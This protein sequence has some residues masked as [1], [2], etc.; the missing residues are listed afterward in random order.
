MKMSAQFNLA[1]AQRLKSLTI[2]VNHAIWDSDFGSNFKIFLNKNS[3]IESF[4][5][6]NLFDI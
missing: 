5:N 3:D 6:K 2:T 4:L 1:T